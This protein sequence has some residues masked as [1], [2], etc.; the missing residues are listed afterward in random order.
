M[1]AEAGDPA[2]VNST[3]QDE[4]SVPCVN[5]GKLFRTAR[6]ALQH[7]RQ[8]KIV[9]DRVQLPPEP[10]AEPEPQPQN[11]IE[12]IPERFYWGDIKGTDFERLIN[13]S[14][15]K[16]VYWRKNL[17]KLP[18]GRTGKDFIR[19]VTRL[20]NAWIE[21]S[22]LGVVSM[23]A[24]HIMPALLLQ[25][26]S[27]TSKAH[28]HV[29]ALERRL[30][31]WRRGDIEAL[32]KEAET[33]Q[34]R[35]PKPVE[36][37]TIEALSKQFKMKMEKGDVNGAIK[38]LTNNMSGGVLPLD[39]QT[40]NLLRQKHPEGRDTNENNLLNGP[41]QHIDPIVFECIDEEMVS[42]AALSTQGGSGPSGMD[43]DGW[44]K[45]LTSKVYGDCGKDLRKSIAKLTRKLCTQ[46]TNDESLQGFLA[47]RLVP[48]DKQ[49]GVRPIGVGEVLR[50]I[51]GKL[52][53]AVVKEDVIVGGS[54]VQMCSGQKG[55]S[56]AAIHAMRSVFE[57]EAA[58][59][60]I[61]VDAANAFNNINR[62]ALLHN[63]Q[64]L[65]P[66]F[67]RYVN[68]CYR[69]PAR[70]FVIGGVELKSNEG[71][72][73][74]DPI[75]MA[76]YAIGITPL[77]NI[78]LSIIADIPDKMAAFADDI[79]SVGKLLSLKRWWSRITTVGPHFG[80][81]PQPTKSWLIVKEEYLDE[82]EEIFRETNIQVSKDG[83]RHLGAVIGSI[84]FKDRYCK[85]IVDKWCKELT[86]LSEIAVTQPQSAY[87]CYTSG[88]QHRFSYFL[89]TIPEME[90]YL[91]PI[92]TIVRHQLIPAI[93]GGKIVNDLERDLL[94]LPPRLGGLGLKNVCEIAPIEHENSRQFT[95]HLQNQILNLQPPNDNETKTK[96]AIKT[97]KTRRNQDKQDRIRA[98]MTDDQK[99]IHEANCYTGASNWLTNLPIRDQG[100]D[101]NKEQFHDALRIRYDWSIPR[102]PSECVCGNRFDI[103]HA[104]SCKKGGYVTL[105]HNEVRDIT[106]KLLDEVCVNV[107]NEP[108]L[109]T[110]DGEGLTHKTANT[111]EGA[112][113]DVS[114]T[115]FWTPGQRAFFD[116][117]VFDLSARR[118]RGLE[119]SKCFQRNENE[120]K[121]HYNERVNSV[122]NGTFTPLVFSTNGGMGR[123]CQTF[124]KRLAVMLAEKRGVRLHESISFIRSKISFSL[125]RSSLLCIRGSRSIWSRELNTNDI[126]LTNS[127]SRVSNN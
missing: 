88:Y 124:Y 100:Y 66:I 72:T 65:C 83:E 10:E 127:R 21:D 86:L 116:I 43:A 92:E 87:T 26:P 99:R 57:N 90:N 40:I 7:Q 39:D 102:L 123:E 1:I 98:E 68:N 113:L 119:L 3:H 103:S 13:N 53:M 58:E 106:A 37:K 61:L 52:V 73:Q 8:C 107:R 70:L 22:P 56:E 36:K 82:A 122:E 81:F 91:T 2:T 75:G 19:E 115:G 59:A 93:T 125:L 17:F 55:G 111:S 30:L 95:K 49:P 16:I 47:A 77:L 85:E 67:A 74:G 104:L 69:S 20:L 31:Q 23:K 96:A 105:R 6:G 84:N 48:L 11:N 121:R 5:C 108:R 18:S 9:T 117:R 64:V 126:E 120:K 60:V 50:R 33:L 78:M 76:V 35:L 24:V 71:T 101:L 89:R 42:K 118:Y 110:L 94:S 45:P 32:V 62:K 114:A 44:R 79:T 109:I 14:Y 97:E 80:Y 38:L 27:K 54:R 46:E 41:I 25:K 12:R 15:E 63:V 34:S 28:D 51:S 29:E 4:P 112:R